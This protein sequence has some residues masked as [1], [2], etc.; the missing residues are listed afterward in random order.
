VC[1]QPRVQELLQQ[2]ERRAHGGHANLLLRT[3]AELMP[4]D[5]SAAVARRDGDIHEADRVTVPVG[6][7]SGDRR[8]GGDERG[9]Q[10]ASPPAAM[11]CATCPFTAVCAASSSSGTPT[12][13]IL[14]SLV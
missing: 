2:I 3:F 12:A 14:F 4:R 5:L 6:L 10:R 11:A 8:D 7:R 9:G 13:A 1:R